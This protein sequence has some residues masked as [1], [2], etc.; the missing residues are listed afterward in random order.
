[1][2]FIFQDP[3]ASLNPRMT[4][5]EIIER[6]MK[7]YGLLNVKKPREEI[8]HLLEKVGLMEDHLDSYPHELSGG[9]QQRV[10]IARA[11]GLNTQLLVLD[12]PTSSLDVSVQSQ[13]INLLLGLHDEFRLSYLFISHNLSLIRFTSHRIGV[14]YLGKIV[15]LADKR[16]LFDHTA[17]PYTQA[18]LSA[19]PRVT[20]RGQS[21]RIILRG[22]TPSATHLLEGCRF[23]TRCLFNKEICESEPELR[24]IAPHHYAACHIS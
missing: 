14:M 18:L 2:Q 22:S 21:K 11:L 23:R 5:Q 3:M 19:I 15:E 24:E 13:I 6:P 7:I 4:T 17:H 20:R 1:M 8:L 12:E 10:G 9:Q 16:D